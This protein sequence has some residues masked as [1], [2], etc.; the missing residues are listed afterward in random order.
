ME[1]LPVK[2]I[3]CLDRNEASYTSILP[4]CSSPRE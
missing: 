3:V 1:G 2:L 4:L